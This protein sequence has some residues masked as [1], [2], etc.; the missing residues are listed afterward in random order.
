VIGKAYE[1]VHKAAHILA[2][3]EER[4][5]AAVQRVYEDL[6]EEMIQQQDTL[7]ELAPAVDHFR[8][9]TASYAAGLFHC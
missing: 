2:N 5:G 3:H 6:L 9:V 1:W 7:G 8:K 4:S